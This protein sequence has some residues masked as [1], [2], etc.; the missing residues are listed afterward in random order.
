MKRL[1]LIIVLAVVALGVLGGVLWADR[2]AAVA[3]TR[4]EPGRPAP[5]FALSDVYGKTF[6]LKEFKGRIVVLD[7]ISVR[8]PWSLGYDAELRR[9]W[10]KYAQKGVQ[11][12]AINANHN[13]TLGEVKIHQIKKDL[14]LPILKDPGN[15]VANTYRA[16]TT[17]HVYVVDPTGQLVYMGQPCDR[18]PT[19]SEPAVA[20]NT[21]TG[22]LDALLAGKQVQPRQT[23][24]WGCTV[25]RVQ[26]S[27]K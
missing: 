21:L 1:S 17:P 14:T 16:L 12:L 22:V 15:K 25:K 24:P 18:G 4:A 19:A 11:F 7:F 10:R 5:D 20:A 26:K 8:C 23:Q 3:P 2:D 13:D 6:T 9:M 27:T